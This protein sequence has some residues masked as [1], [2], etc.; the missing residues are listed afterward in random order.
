MIFYT[1][2]QRCICH[3]VA[4]CN[5]LFNFCSYS[6]VAVNI[7]LYYELEV[8]ILFERTDITTNTVIPVKNQRAE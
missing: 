7:K 3:V 8:I 1:A 2:K 6:S 4:H 5:V